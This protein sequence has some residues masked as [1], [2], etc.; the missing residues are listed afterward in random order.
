MSRR[1]KSWE[2]DLWYFYPAYLGAYDPPDRL[3]NTF[4]RVVHDTIPEIGKDLTNALEVIPVADRSYDRVTAA[5]EKWQARYN[6]DSLTASRGMIYCGW[7]GDIATRW[8]AGL[9]PGT[10]KRA[11]EQL[12]PTVLAA[13]SF[14]YTHPGRDMSYESIHQRFGFA[15]KEFPSGR[16]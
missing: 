6:M 1:K 5:T 9:L 12:T 8:L 16:A 3:D 2:D 13:E 10:P 14:S 11:Y 15:A 7:G 4:V